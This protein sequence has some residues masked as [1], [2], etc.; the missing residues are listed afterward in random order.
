MANPA[1]GGRLA[2]AVLV[3]MLLSACGPEAASYAEVDPIIRTH[4]ISCHSAKPAHQGF[5]L[6]PV[7]VAFDA[8]ADVAKRAVR[9][10]ALVVTT[11]TMPLGNETGMTDTE[12]QIIGKWVDAGAPI[13]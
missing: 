3:P 4:C 10:K 5:A 12:R 2:I 1:N 8:P 11:T 7:G 13:K 9:I 6:P